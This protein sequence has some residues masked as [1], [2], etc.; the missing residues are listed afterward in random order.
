[1]IYLI[2]IKTFIKSLLFHIYLG[3][4]KTTQDEINYRYNICS[5]CEEY[6]EL[7]SMCNVCGCGIGNK[8]KFLNKLAWADQ[9]CPL[10]KWLKIER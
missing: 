5:D 3:L 6:N 9:E 2:R 1:M 10:G 4:P 8:S 7:G